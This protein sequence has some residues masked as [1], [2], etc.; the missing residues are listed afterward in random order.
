MK[1]SIPV[2]SKMRR[3][4][5][6]ERWDLPV[7]AFAEG[8]HG[9]DFQA[10]DYKHFRALIAAGRC[11]MCGE[12]VER[13]IWWAVGEPLS[14]KEGRFIAEAMGHRECVEYAVEVCPWLRVAVYRRMSD[15]RD[16]TREVPDPD[17]PAVWGLV[18]ARNPQLYE[19]GIEVFLSD[20]RL[21]KLYGYVGGRLQVVTREVANELL[22]AVDEEAL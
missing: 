18:Q 3:R 14:L 11:A 5:K 2:P 4:P 20:V 10:A 19:T 22:R 8:R 21:R 12:A 15:R 9:V 13:G 1:G 7:P 16:D 6:D 17:K